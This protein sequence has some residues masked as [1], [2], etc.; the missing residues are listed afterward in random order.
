MSVRFATVHLRLRDKWNNANSQVTLWAVL[1]TE[2]SPVPKKEKG[3]EWLLLTTHPVSSLSDAVDVVKGYSKRW[4]VEEF[5]RTWKTV[6]GVEHTQLRTKE[7]IEKW[8]VMKGS[9]AMRIERLKHPGRK[10][11]E[12]PASVEFSREEIDAVIMLR[13]PKGHTVGSMPTVGEMVLWVADLGGYTG[14]SS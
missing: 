14:K 1:A 7:R 4:P 5:H 9:V 8:A 12:E 11:P 2:T 6:C 3:L 13:E 10:T